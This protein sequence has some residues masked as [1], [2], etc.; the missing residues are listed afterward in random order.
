MFERG[1]GCLNP[2]ESFL[3]DGQNVNSG[4]NQCLTRELVKHQ[5]C[6]FHKIGYS[7]A[8]NPE[9]KGVKIPA[10]LTRV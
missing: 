3:R 9:R 10:S 8:E 2:H 1:I 4:K 7:E 5:L 6:H